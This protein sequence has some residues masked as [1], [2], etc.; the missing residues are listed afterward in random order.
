MAA[1]GVPGH[2]ISHI[3]NHAGLTKGGITTAVYNTYDYGREMREALE[4]WANHLT[5]IIEG[6]DNV[7]PLRA[8][9]P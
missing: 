8:A 6:K 3:L 9:K 4:L 7:T 5:A 1:L 2:V